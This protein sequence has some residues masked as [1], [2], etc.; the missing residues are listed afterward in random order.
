LSLGRLL[1]VVAV[2]LRTG[3]EDDSPPAA[4]TP[5]FPESG[6]SAISGPTNDENMMKRATASDVLMTWPPSRRTE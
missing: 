3:V 6:Y 4:K 2:T 1:V 5:M